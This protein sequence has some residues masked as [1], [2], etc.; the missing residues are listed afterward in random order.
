MISFR[1]FSLK[2]VLHSSKFWAREPVTPGQ[3]ILTK[4][5]INGSPLRFAIT[6]DG[7]QCSV[8]SNCGKGYIGGDVTGTVFEMSV[9]I[10]QIKL[11]L[12]THTAI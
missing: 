12:T 7:C 5:L 4:K 1:L 8:L 9:R 10:V 2:V 3:L 6:L 11:R